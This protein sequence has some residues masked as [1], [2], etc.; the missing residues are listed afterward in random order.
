MIDIAGLLRQILAQVEV[1]QRHHHNLARGIGAKAGWTGGDEDTEGENTSLDP[2]RIDAGNDTW[3]VASYCVL[4]TAD[5]PVIPGSAFFDFHEIMVHATQENVAYRLR[6]AYGTSYAAAIIAGTF[7]EIEFVAAGNKAEEGPV[8]IH[9]V[10]IP[11]GTKVFISAWALATD[12]GWIDI[13]FLLHEY[14]A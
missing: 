7:S 3:S 2:F 1:V 6:V 5:T 14:A 13:T 10:R 11:A 8:E 12:T 9:M 4:G